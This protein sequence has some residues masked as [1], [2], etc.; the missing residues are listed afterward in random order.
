[1]APALETIMASEV[2]IGNRQ[3]K[4]ALIRHRS[5]EE[6]IS[7]RNSRCYGVGK[8]GMCWPSGDLGTLLVWH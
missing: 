4:Q 7:K 5:L 6:G 8:V 3:G 1:M 2:P